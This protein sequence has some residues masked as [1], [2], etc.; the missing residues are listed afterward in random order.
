MITIGIFILLGF[1][2]QRF[3]NKKINNNNLYEIIHHNLKNHISDNSSLIFKE[4]IEYRK[5]K[6][7]HQ[8]LYNNVLNDINNNNHYLLWFRTNIIDKIDYI[9]DNTSTKLNTIIYILDINNNNS[10]KY[11]NKY[12][13]KMKINLY[14]IS[15]CHPNEFIDKVLINN[16][17]IKLNINNYLSPYHFRYTFFGY[18]DKLNTYSDNKLNI[19]IEDIF[20]YI[21]KIEGNNL[22]LTNN[23]NINIQNNKL[24]FI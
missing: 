14:I 20:N 24:I 13:I 9:I 8:K 7:A 2:F 11:L 3:I 17:D 16:E 23:L 5:N 19:S 22:L 12:C 1:L 21:N 15:E 6:I 4:Q 18:L 10:L